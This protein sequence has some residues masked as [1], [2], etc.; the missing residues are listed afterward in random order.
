[1]P[2]DQEHDLPHSVMSFGDHLEE[3]RRRVILA[4]I[5]PLP[6]MI[7]LFP[8]AAS[9]REILSR[10]VFNALRNLGQP[11]QLQAMSPAE[12]LGTDIKLSIICAIV[13]SCPWILWQVWK[14]IEPGLYQQERRFVHLLIPGSAI[15][16]FSGLALLYF[17]MLP[18]MLHVLI[19]FGLPGNQT[20]FP[21]STPTDATTTDSPTAPKIPVVTGQPETLEP[22]SFW[23]SSTD[24]T[25]QV[26]VPVIED[27]VERVRILM[28]PLGAEGMVVQ[29]YRLREYINFILL[30]MV[31]I[32]IA[33]QMPL[34]ILLLGWVGIVNPHTL[35]KNRKYALLV[36]AVVSAIITPADIVSMVIMLIPLYALY[37]L[38]IFLLRFAPADRVYSGSIF[39]GAV[40][41][42]LGRFDR[43]KGNSDDDQ[44]PDN[45]DDPDD[46]DNPSGEQS[47]PRSPQPS[48]PPE[49]TIP[50]AGDEDDL[51]SE[52]D[53]ER[54][55]S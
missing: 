23:I 52:H 8:F 40:E 10:P 26:A 53:Q 43:G 35:K 44:S 36:C 20:S 19:S 48:T 3:L 51:D 29:Q 7:V 11:A 33:F 42:I 54:N 22:G 12:T 14:F 18:L 21:I 6:L 30:L 31:A 9:I 15:L 45:D 32:A 25:L 49:G 37:E 17:G 34:V 50:L 46:F 5:V 27:G 41:E 38:G 28:V 1:M 24:D 2:L 47:G 55:P 39:K 13:L 4:L 16:T